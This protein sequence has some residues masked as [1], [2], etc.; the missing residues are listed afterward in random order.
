MITVCWRCRSS[1]GAGVPDAPASGISP[2]NP[3]TY[4][5]RRI[6][7]WSVLTR[8]PPPSGST[9]QRDDAD[10]PRQPPRNSATTPL[11]EGIAPV[12]TANDSAACSASIPKP[13]AVR[14]A[15]PLRAK[16]KNGPAAAP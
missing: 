9:S 2:H 5:G 14:R 12:Q 15:P 4:P 7:R 3:A 8:V 6:R 1:G 16:S 10:N 13:S 11:A